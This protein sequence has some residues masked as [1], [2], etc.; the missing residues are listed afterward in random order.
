MGLLG[1]KHMVKN[2]PFDADSVNAMINLDMVGRLKENHNLQIG[3]VGTSPAFTRMIKTLTDTPIFELSLSRR[4][5]T[6]HPIIHLFMVKISRS[7]LYQQ[8]HTLITIHHSIRPI[9]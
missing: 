9:K 6:D 4:K 1:S 3:G 8:E 2:L 7:Y 5:D